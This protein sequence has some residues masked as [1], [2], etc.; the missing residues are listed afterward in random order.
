MK[1][2]K[3]LCHL[4]TKHA[5]IKNKPLEYFE[6]RKREQKGQKELLRATTSTNVNALKESFLVANCIAKAKKV[7][8]IGEELILPATIA[9]CHEILGE[10]VG[11]VPLQKR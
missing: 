8:T 3:L 7:F 10:K 9:I 4:E 5:D 1:P 6:R 11:H 2:L